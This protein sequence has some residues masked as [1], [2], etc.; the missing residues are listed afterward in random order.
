M[1]C[2]ISGGE[3]LIPSLVSSNLPSVQVIVHP[4]NTTTQPHQG[5]T[6]YMYI[7]CLTVRNR[8]NTYKICITTRYG[9]CSI[10]PSIKL[11]ISG[12]LTA[13]SVNSCRGREITRVSETG[14]AAV[15]ALAACFFLS[16]FL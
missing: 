6:L 12:L 13:V 8:Y 3:R 1:L 4:E 7:L 5:D 14:E 9:T 10:Q 11:K 2:H 15:C 16:P